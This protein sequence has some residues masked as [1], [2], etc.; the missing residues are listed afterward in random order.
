MFIRKFELDPDGGIRTNP[1]FQTS[2][3][4]SAQTVTIS[5]LASGEIG[6]YD[7]WLNGRIHSGA[8]A[9]GHDD[10]ST[11]SREAEHGSDALWAVTQ[12]RSPDAEV[13]A[14]CGFPSSMQLEPAIPGTSDGNWRTYPWNDQSLAFHEPQA[15]VTGPKSVRGRTRGRTRGRMVGRLFQVG[16]DERRSEEGQGGPRQ[17][18]GR[19]RRDASKPIAGRR[20][21]PGAAS[22]IHGTKRTASS[23]FEFSA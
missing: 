21:S 8:M 18:E 5:Y 9:D 15:T 23:V 14:G 7:D 22:M 3:V 13:V 20:Q 1:F 10:A 11:R 16:F 2:P 6:C 12:I 4:R 19:L 17:A